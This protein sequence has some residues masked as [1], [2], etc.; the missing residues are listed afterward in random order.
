MPIFDWRGRTAEAKRSRDSL[1]PVTE[2]GVDQLRAIGVAPVSI[3]VAPPKS[4]LSEDILARL[5]KPVN[6]EDLMVFS[7]QMYTLNG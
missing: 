5:T 1:K 2:G 6:N 3:V 7:R 4:A